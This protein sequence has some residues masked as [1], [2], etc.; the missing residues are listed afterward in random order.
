MKDCVEPRAVY[1]ETEGLNSDWE[2]SKLLEK[3]LKSDEYGVYESEQEKNYK[4]ETLLKLAEIMKQWIARVRKKRGMF[5]D[6]I[7]N[8][9]CKLL[10][11]GSYKLGVSEPSGD[12][13]V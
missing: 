6:A 3:M 8:S 1:E 2:H 12:I 10:P 5:E 9:K 11:Y 13:D 4:E 7:E